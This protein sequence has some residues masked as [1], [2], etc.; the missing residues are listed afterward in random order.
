MRLTLRTLLAY[1]DEILEPDQAEQLSQKIRESDFAS[2]L[3]HRIRNSMG[4]LRISS[5]A[6]HGTGLGNDANTVAQ[7]LD[8]Q[9]PGDR[10]S[11]FEKICLE[12]DMHL[13]EV[14]SC[15]QILTLVLGEP[16]EV[17][18]PLRARIYAIPH[19]YESLPT[20]ADRVPPIDSAQ[21]EDTP[22]DNGHVTPRSLAAPSMSSPGGRTAAPPAPQQKS[23]LWIPATIAIFLLGIA[24]TYFVTQRN[25]NPIA[26]VPTTVADAAPASPSPQPPVQQAATVPSTTPPAQS[27]P[28]AAE[29]SIYADPPARP[30]PLNPRGGSPDE[31]ETE[32]FADPDA[33]S[34]T[35]SEFPTAEDEGLNPPETN[36]T[37]M[38]VPGS[39]PIGS[40]PVGSD[41]VGLDPEATRLESMPALTDPT[42]AGAFDT[43]TDLAD[44]AEPATDLEEPMFGDSDAPTTSGDGLDPIASEPAPVPEAPE[45]PQDFGRFLLSHVSGFRHQD[46]WMRIGTQD[47]LYEGMQVRVPVAFDPPIL[48]LGGS[49]SVTLGGRSEIEVLPF[50][51]GGVPQ[52]RMP[53]GRAIFSCTGRDAKRVAIT[54]GNREL[55]V[56]FDD[57]AAE[58]ALEVGPYFMPGD[59]PSVTT[60]SPRIRVW[61]STGR[62]VLDVDGT[63]VFVKER[64]T[65]TVLADQEPVLSEEIPLPDWVDTSHLA[66]IEEQALLRL[67]PMLD[68]NQPLPLTL[69]EIVQSNAS[70]SDLKS[71]A[72]RALASFDR[73]G[74]IVESLDQ[75]RMHAYWTKHVEELQAGVAR[76]AEQSQ[77]I[78]DSLQASYGPN[79]TVIHEMLVGYSPAQLQQG[80]GARLVEALAHRELPYRVVAAVVL[81]QITGKTHLY[82]AKDSA[83][84]RRPRIAEWE[85][86]LRRGD[87]NYSSQ[88]QPLG[89]SS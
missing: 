16:A 24:V 18:E 64:E 84:K 74:P 4:R 71:L 26:A 77:A 38:N 52:I 42:A 25:A 82:E 47:H 51:R 66:S 29:D 57:P 61:P 5:P 76:G 49:I 63:E 78:L 41:P 46:Q 17:S 56:S 54:V 39:D 33:V 35:G 81:R 20:G 59:D 12:S 89:L 73:F 48:V 23:T 10:V 87:V 53:F 3:V 55:L 8:N 15:H 88:P 2:G 69:A 86:R 45:V 9:L 72:M 6:V 14:A 60:R 21:M 85:D 62:I 1:L 37:P 68:P 27:Q 50:V 13:A 22:T 19:Q 31:A 79:A 36:V 75:D 80:G 44:T 11:D 32:G 34:A 7:Y 30:Q 65:A 83:S 43:S 40:D 67:K 70:Q 58:F 28:A